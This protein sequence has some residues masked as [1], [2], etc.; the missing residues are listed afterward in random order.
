[1]QSDVEDVDSDIA[2]L[3]SDLSGLLAM[4]GSDLD[5][6][7]PAKQTVTSSPPDSV[8]NPVHPEQESPS[9]IESSLDPTRQI[10]SETHELQSQA[11]SKPRSG[12]FSSFNRRNKRS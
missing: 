6:S 3:T 5:A 10:E 8:D 1:M 2:D 9:E 7:V 12:L 4:H 11:D